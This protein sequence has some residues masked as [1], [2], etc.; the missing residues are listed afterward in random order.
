V[1]FVEPTIAPFEQGRNRSRGRR[2]RLAATLALA[3]AAVMAAAGPSG[4]TPT[5]REAVGWKISWKAPI[6]SAGPNR[7]DRA[8]ALAG[9]ATY[10]LGKVSRVDTTLAA[11]AGLPVSCGKFPLAGLADLSGSTFTARPA[12]ACNGT[13]DL[14]V[15]AQSGSGA[16]AS[17]SSALHAPVALAD[18]GP[19][20]T[21]F[22]GVASGTSRAVTLSW[23]TDPDPDVVGYRIRR[24][25]V[26][27]AEVGADIRTYTDSLVSA[28][29]YTY[30]VS[31]LRWGAG[32]PDSTAIGSPAT[33]PLTAHVVDG[34]PPASIGGQDGGSGGSGSGSG[35]SGGASGSGSGS[36]SSASHHAL[37]PA[38]HAN[39]SLPS[40]GSANASVPDRSKYRSG[41]TKNPNAT[42]TT[43]DDGFRERL[44]YKSG[45]ASDRVELSDPARSRTVSRSVR[46]PGHHRPG[47][48]VP[49]AVVVV[50]AAASLQVR[51]LLGR[52]GAAAAAGG[53]PDLD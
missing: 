28:G 47:L 11:P 1:T 13:Y 9:T 34:A 25:D 12:L 43:L 5:S 16:L 22:T 7:F 26:V 18:P 8:P 15:V 53:G 23:N 36:G 50:L 52:A 21:G 44:P 40:V 19:A 48:L 32:G 29:T 20:P 37:P 38:S 33:A 42:G 39:A 27:V 30:N 46:V 4:A 51:S 35:S 41:G 2:R 17:R 24:D 45:T 6:T 14:S 10:A 3:G 31:G 49:L